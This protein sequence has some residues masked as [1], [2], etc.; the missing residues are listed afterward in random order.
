MERQKV[1]AP[2]Y[3]FVGAEKDDDG[4]YTNSCSTT[5]QKLE[6]ISL[7]ADKISKKI[8]AIESKNNDEKK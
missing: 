3:S 1:L 7:S 8:T 5:E 4:K 2:T 6:Y